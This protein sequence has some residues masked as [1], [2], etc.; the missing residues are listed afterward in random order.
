MV[1]KE[2]A[3]TRYKAQGTRHKVQG[4]RKFQVPSIKKEKRRHKKLF[5]CA[6][7]LKLD[8]VLS[9]DLFL[10]PCAL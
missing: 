8:L 6:F 9:L 1:G 5:S 4:T 3:S 10:A 7:I 2:K